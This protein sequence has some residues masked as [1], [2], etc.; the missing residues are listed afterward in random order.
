MKWCLLLHR[1]FLLKWFSNRSAQVWWRD[2]EE[3]A[4]SSA[5][6][7]SHLSSSKMVITHF[8]FTQHVTH[9]YDTHRK[10]TFFHIKFSQ[11]SHSK[12]TITIHK[13]VIFT[14]SSVPYQIKTCGNYWFPTFFRTKI[15]IT[16]TCITD[17]WKLFF[18]TVLYYVC[19]SITEVCN[20]LELSAIVCNSL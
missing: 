11:V 10:Q 15:H 3:E 8:P 6:M 12:D 16:E 13:R 2:Q 4:L 7:L 18:H 1:I 14:V 5:Q 9:F 19:Y 20:T 17:Y